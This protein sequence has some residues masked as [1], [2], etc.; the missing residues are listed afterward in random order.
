VGIYFVALLAC[1]RLGKM[2]MIG[3][4]AFPIGAYLVAGILLE[5][6]RDLRQGKPT[7][8]AG[9]VYTRESR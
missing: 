2:P 4:P 3:V 9:I 1:S 5:A 6:A 8:W 7:E